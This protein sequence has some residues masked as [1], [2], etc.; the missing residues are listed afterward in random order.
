MPSSEKMTGL[1]NYSI[2]INGKAIADAHPVFSIHI[3][4]ESFRIP[5]ATIVFDDVNQYVFSPGKDIVIKIGYDDSLNEVFKGVI[6]KNNFKAKNGNQTLVVECKSKAYILTLGNKNKVYL[7]K[8]VSDIFSQ[9]I[10]EAGLTG[11][12]EATTDQASQIVQYNVCDWDFMLSHAEINGKVVNVLKDSSINIKEPEIGEPKL[13]FEIGADIIEFESEYDARTQIQKSSIKSMNWDSKNQK[14]LKESPS[15]SYGAFTGLDPQKMAKDIHQKDYNLIHPGN[16]SQAE[17]TAWANGKYLKSVFSQIRGRLKSFGNHTVSIGDTIEIAGFNTTTNGKVY[18]SGIK[19]EVS[20]GE[21][22]TYY[23]FGL[24]YD[25]HSE[26]YQINPALNSGLLNLE[27]G[28]HIGKVVKIV[29]DPESNFQI[30]LKIPSLGEDLPIFAR[31]TF[32]DAGN[33]RGICFFPEVNDEVVVGFMNND[34]RF[35]IILGYLYSGKNQPPIVPDHNNY[36][37]GI[38]TKSGIEVIFDDEDKKVTIKTP[39]GNKITLDDT[40]SSIKVI[41]K[42][43]NTVDMEKGGITVVSQKD[44]KV[45][46]KGNIEINASGDLKLSGTNVSIKAKAQLS[47]EGSAGVEI[48]SNAMTTIKGSLVKIN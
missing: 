38:Y 1:V 33:K 36:M 29:D 10:Q 16:L 32:P 47:E 24:S 40:D 41:D 37:K 14:T 48:K 13:K 12:V 7:K 27:Q 26:N 25:W 9:L 19:H 5:T 44:I 39:G 17:L 45:E 30:Q 22:F 11:N 3:Y 28:L 21:W 6:V 46:A 34:F 18:V 15:K 23:Q 42:N 20:G 4:A 43:N 31:M 35:P 8:T 2:I